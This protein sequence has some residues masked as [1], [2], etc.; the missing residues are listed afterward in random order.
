MESTV[1]RINSWL[2]NYLHHPD[3]GEETIM[4]KKIW[5]LLNVI[6]LPFLILMS[7]VIG[8]HEG[9]FVVF[10]NIIWI[11]SIVLSLLA[12]HFQKDH[13]E[14]Y[15][16]FSQIV[17]LVLSIV[18]AYLMGGLLHAGGVIFI[19]L[20]APIYAITLPNK[21]HAFFIFLFYMIAMIT[22]TLLQPDNPKSYILYYYFLGFIIGISMAFL[23]LYYYTTQFEK[24]KKEEKKRMRELDEFKTKFYTNITHEFR[25]PLTIILGMADQIKDNPE[26]WKNEGLKMIK[27]NGKNL[28]HLINQMLDLSKLD[29]SLM[30]VNLI[31]DNMAIYIKYLVESFHSLADIKDI[32]ILFK[33]EP[34]EIIMDFDPD[35]IMDIISNLLSNAIKFTPAGGLIHVSVLKKDDNSLKNQLIITV[36]DSGSGIPKEHLLKVFNRYFQSENNKEQLN[37]GSGLGLAFTKELVKL[38]KGKIGVKSTL[39]KGSIFTVSLP[40]TNNGQRGHEHLLKEFGLT[41]HSS[42]P[43]KKTNNKPKENKNEKLVLLIVED[44]KDVKQY[45]KSILSSE[46]HIEFSENGKEGF[47]KAIDIIPDLV[48][49]D[50]MMPVMDGLTFCEKLK[51]DLITSHIPVVILTARADIDSKMEGLNAGADAYLAKP[52]NKKE[53]FVRIEKLIE[54]RKSLQ[55]RYKTLALFPDAAQH[56]TDHK[57]SIEDSFMQKVRKNLEIHLCEEEFGITELCSSM[58]MSRSQLYRKFSALTNTSIH[59]FIRKLRLTKAKELLLGTELN[60]TEVAYDTGFKNLSHFSRVYSEEFGISPSKARE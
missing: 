60:V 13:I 9:S 11:S 50:V 35:K 17:I 4:V 36:K 23:G 43:R 2:I 41:E 34:E 26:E 6:G 12:F 32:K 57:L 31:Q 21:K 25:T 16:L 10:L 22:V 20:I 54:L 51:S 53:L 49:S 47:E 40:I 18:K 33:S 48:I 39:N 8:T 28:L 45:L 1:Q 14:A 27:H 58:A 19:G 46:Y 30:P 3:D 5:W 7:A 24:L 37:S 44:N 59:Q 56:T 29:A 15:A 42:I 38:L 52:F 55:E